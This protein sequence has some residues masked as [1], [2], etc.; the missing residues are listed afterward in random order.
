MTQ[1]KQL[2]KLVSDFCEVRDWTQFHTLK[3]L[4]IGLST[5]SNE[6]LQLF[7]FKSEAES[8][9]LL[10]TQPD[11]IQDELADVFYYLLRIAD[12]YDLDLEACLRAKME[13]N[14]AKYP[15]ASSKGNNLK[16]DEIEP[17]D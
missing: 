10:K 16:Y 12:L 9:A 4:T 17:G 2:Q 14:E 3:D 15:V 1:L 8:L 13:K 11:K 7:R 5:E 6:L